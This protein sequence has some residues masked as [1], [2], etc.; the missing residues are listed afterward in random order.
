MTVRRSP[1]PTASRYGAWYGVRVPREVVEDPDALTV[2]RIE[3]EQ[4]MNIR[5]VMVERYGPDRFLADVG[6]DHVARD[7]W[8]ELW[9]TDRPSGERLGMVETVNAEGRFERLWLWASAR[10]TTPREAFSWSVGPE[11]ER[12]GPASQRD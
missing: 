7:D 4:A 2:E 6:A 5:S 12:Y 1:T 11:L 3:S 8:G 9:D 10:A